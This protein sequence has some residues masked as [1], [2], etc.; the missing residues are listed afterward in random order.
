[1]DK[2]LIDVLIVVALKEESDAFLAGGFFQLG[3]DQYLENYKY[4]MFT[5]IDGAKQNRTGIYVCTEKPGLMASRAALALCSKFRVKTVLNIGISGRLKDAI[6]GDVVVPTYVNPADHSSSFVDTPEGYSLILGGDPSEVG[7]SAQKALRSSRLRNELKLPT[8]IEYARGGTSLD[9]PEQEKITIW[10]RDKKLAGEP[11]IVEGSFVVGSAVVKST[12]FKESVLQKNDRNFVAVDMESG[13]IASGL[14]DLSTRPEFFA[15][16]AISDPATLEKSEFDAV[17]DG[18]IRRW[19]MNS[20]LSVVKLLICQPLFHVRDETAQRPVQQGSLT[21]EDYNQHYP[22]QRLLEGATLDDFNKRF[23]NLKLNQKRYSFTAFLEAVR[24]KPRNGNFLVQ[25]RGGSGKSALLRKTQIELDRHGNADTLFINVRKLFEVSEGSFSSEIVNSKIASAGLQLTASDKPVVVFLDELYGRDEER[26]LLS[27]VR[28][29]LRDRQPTFVMAFGKDHYELLSVAKDFAR[30]PYLYDIRLDAI[31]DVKTVPIEDPLLSSIVI[32]GMIA[33]SQSDHIETAQV[34]DELRSKD[35]PYISHFIISLYLQNRENPSFPTRNGTLEILHAME[36][37]Y[38]ENYPRD[39]FSFFDLC[40]EALRSYCRELV[41]RGVPAERRIP[42]DR[43]ARFAHFPKIVQ[44]GLIANALVHILRRFNNEGEDVFG[45]L[46]VDKETFFSLVFTGAINSAVKDILTDPKL[47]EDVLKAAERLLDR[48]DP[49]G[50]SYALYLFGRAS[51]KKGKAIAD[52]ALNA[53]SA[54]FT[55]SPPAR[56]VSSDE[57]DRFWRLARRSWYISRSMRDDRHSRTATD[58]YIR[59]VLTDQ[60]EDDLNRSF[61]LEYYGDHE[62]LGITVELDQQDTAKDWLTLTTRS[63]LRRR[64]TRLLP[65]EQHTPTDLV[66]YDHICILTYFSLVRFRHEKRLLDEASRTEELRL[67][68]SLLNAGL[69]L[70]PELTGFLAMIRHALG[71]V[72]YDNIDAIVDVYK[73][74]TRVRFGWSDRK[75]APANFVIESIGAHV[76]GAMFLAD[77]LADRVVPDLTDQ[78]RHQLLRLVLHH[79]VGETYLGDFHP[80]DRKTKEREPGEIQR[81]SSLATYQDMQA[82]ASIRDLYQRFE[83]LHAD[84]IVSLARDFD[85]LDAVLQGYVYANKF[86]DQPNRRTF[87]EHYLA[88]IANDRVREIAE[89]IQRRAYKVPITAKKR[90]PAKRRSKGRR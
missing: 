2:Q 19:A 45:Q 42:A 3:R 68:T 88:E 64:I 76:F 90:T 80:N 55:Q 24:N 51:S 23:A 79:D 44:I 34:L 9:A 43:Y 86:P 25:G 12:H 89:E 72:A 48:K 38:L 11:S 4:Q 31:I 13:Y 18:I 21:D 81:I 56:T 74:K 59:F 14:R 75:M 29:L 61:H 60:Y 65:A 5:F 39:Q 27:A 54:E 15:V 63:I 32:E 26:E 70:R 17:G 53:M 22:G 40:V 8:L 10:Q 57:D 82:M 67:A 71:Q 20:V 52:R 46:A 35:F 30:S 36:S 37:L 7:S 58:Q 50:L 85:K 33:T 47:E 87:F 62:G 28:E 77:I 41:K 49:K 84:R 16:R 1:M 69:Q 73:L 83:K 78:E 66:E 6:V